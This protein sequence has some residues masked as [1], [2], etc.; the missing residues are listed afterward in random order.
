MRWQSLLGLFFLIPP[1]AVLTVLVLIPAFDALRFSLGL[2]PE[3]NVSYASGLN[4]IR[5]AHPTLAVFGKLL[6]SPAFRQNLGLTMFVTLASVVL[7]TLLSYVLAVYARFGQGRFVAIMRTLY[8]LPM[9]IPG[10]IAA[11]AITTFY[12]DNGLLEVLLGRIGVGY[13]SPIRHDWGIVLGSVW[14][15]I[16][17]AVLM[18]SSGLDGLPEEQVE[19]ARDAG[20]NFWTILTRIVLPLNVVPL[21]IVLT[22]SFIGVFGSFTVPYLLGPAAPQMLGVSMQLNFGSFRQPQV[23]V[24]MAVFSFV[25]CALVGYVYVLATLRQN[26]GGQSK[27]SSSC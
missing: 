2:V 20:A 19:A 22:F 26:R 3:D 17:F 21:L 9:F 7:L 5:S 18:L 25:V 23:A 4:V 6:A 10:I 13:V 1:L 11:Y 15:G 12:G 24:S 27:V 14:T 16:P 8:L